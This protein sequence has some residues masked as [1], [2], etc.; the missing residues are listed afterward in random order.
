MI[1]KRLHT[2][3]FYLNTKMK[4]YLTYSPPVLEIYSKNNTKILNSI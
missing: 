2:D 4:M 3:E 1:S